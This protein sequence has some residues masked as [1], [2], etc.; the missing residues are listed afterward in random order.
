MTRKALTCEDGHAVMGRVMGM[1]PRP[2]HDGDPRPPAPHRS[3]TGEL[4]EAPPI[5]VGK[6]LPPPLAGA[7]M[8]G[9][10]WME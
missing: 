2:D 8:A 9:A 4:S 1:R 6:R 7:V 10:V 3:R 5:E